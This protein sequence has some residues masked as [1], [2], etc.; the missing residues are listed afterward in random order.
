MLKKNGELKV[1]EEFQAYLANLSTSKIKRINPDIVK[2]NFK[3]E[4]VE[5]EYQ[6]SFNSELN[7]LN[8]AQQDTEDHLKQFFT[9]VERSE[10]AFPYPPCFTDIIHWAF[11]RAKGIREK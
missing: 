1:E 4:V 9:H 11:F 7:G 8:W 2:P 6:F 3:A 5:R 10:G